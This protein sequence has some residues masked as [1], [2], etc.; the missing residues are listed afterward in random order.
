MFNF[1]SFLVFN[2]AHSQSMPK[3]NK[4]GR[5][6][7]GT[8]HRVYIAQMNG[9]FFININRVSRNGCKDQNIGIIKTASN[10][11]P[12]HVPSSRAFILLLALT[13]P[14]AREKTDTTRGILL[15]SSSQKGWPLCMYQW[16]QPLMP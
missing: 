6:K 14:A 9:A 13:H 1:A 7:G 8:M 16:I 4:C 12:Q 2:L 10:K 11:N 15:L 3:V 5:K